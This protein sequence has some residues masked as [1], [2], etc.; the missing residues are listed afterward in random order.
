MNSL[1][2]LSLLFSLPVISI[3][4]DLL[5]V[6]PDVWI[7]FFSFF[8]WRELLYSPSFTSNNLFRLLI[9][10]PHLYLCPLYSESTVASRNSDK[11]IYCVLAKSFQLCPTLCN[12]MDCS[13][14]GPPSMEF[15]RQE[16]WK[17]LL[18]RRFSW[19]FMLEKLHIF[20]P[21]P[22][23]SVKRSR[24]PKQLWIEILSCLHIFW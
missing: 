7:F 12:P 22:D 5:I 11:F 19:D 23:S 17:R 4:K 24:I 8:I 13:P 10:L 15:S 18:N 6:F 14:P 20:G 3:R 16:H 2:I 1:L 9:P 21:L